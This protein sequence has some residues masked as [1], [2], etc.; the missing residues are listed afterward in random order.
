M[1]S[2][3]L[4]LVSAEGRGIGEKMEGLARAGSL[5]GNREFR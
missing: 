4:P 2:Q 3:D 1:L 5:D